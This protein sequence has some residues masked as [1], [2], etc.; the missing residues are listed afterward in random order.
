DEGS[1]QHALNAAAGHIRQLLRHDP[2]LQGVYDS[3][4][5]ARI[6]SA[7][8]VSDLNS[9]LDKLELDPARLAHAEQRLS[10]IFDMARKFKVEP[11]DLPALQSD[12][13]NQLANSRNAGDIEALEKQAEEARVHYGSLAEQL[14]K[15]RRETGKAL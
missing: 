4:E 15:A 12:W 13:Q 6:A 5:S 14:S 11:E 2:Q 9:Y 1:A 3:I 7:E 10:A 8:A